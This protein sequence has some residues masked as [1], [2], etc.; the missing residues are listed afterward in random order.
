MPLT[1]NSGWH[2]TMQTTLLTYVTRLL[3]EALSSLAVK[4]GISGPYPPLDGWGELEQSVLGSK[5]IHAGKF[6]S[7]NGNCKCY[8]DGYKLHQ[9]LKNVWLLWYPNFD[10]ASRIMQFRSIK[11]WFICVWCSRIAYLHSQTTPSYL[12]KTASK[13]TIPHMCGRCESKSC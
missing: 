7:S 8:S 6:H 13:T 9:H 11:M 4:R 12:L 10:W 3:M 1:Q 5:E 2:C